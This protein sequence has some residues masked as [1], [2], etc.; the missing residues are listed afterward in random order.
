M[1]GGGFDKTGSQSGF[2]GGFGCTSC[3][4]LGINQFCFYQKPRSNFS[5][6]VHPKNLDVVGERSEQWF[7]C[8]AQAVRA[9]AAICE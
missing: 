9:Q 2:D 4:N 6:G 7:A 1:R 8:R 3:Q 5:D